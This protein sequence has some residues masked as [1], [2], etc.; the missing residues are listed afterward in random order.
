M[1]LIDSVL[2]LQVLMDVVFCVVFFHQFYL[3]L[4]IKYVGVGC[5]PWLRRFIECKVNYSDSGAMQRRARP[6]Q[7]QQADSSPSVVVCV[8]FLWALPF[9]SPC[10][11]DPL[12]AWKHVYV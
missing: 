2:I 9:P 4:L 7:A 1:M 6:R 5:S 10:I 3:V 11:K 12:I 8:E